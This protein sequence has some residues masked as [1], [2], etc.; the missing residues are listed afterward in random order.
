MDQSI[1]F[2]D[3][4]T[5]KVVGSVRIN[6]K[7]RESERGTEGKGGGLGDGEGTGGGEG[8]GRG[9]VASWGKKQKGETSGDRCFCMQSSHQEPTVSGTASGQWMDEEE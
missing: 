7:A 2:L 1:S 9:G 5:G 6:L 4:E 8:G 3:N